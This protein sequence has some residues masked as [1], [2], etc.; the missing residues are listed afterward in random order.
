MRISLIHPVYGH[1]D[2]SENLR[3][4]D[5]EFCK[6]PPIV[7]AY[8]A[9]VLQQAGHTV[10]IIDAHNNKLSDSAILKELEGFAPDLLGVRLETYGFYDTLRLV[11][12][13]KPR[14]ANIKVLCGGINL[15]LYPDES[16]AHGFFDYGLIGDADGRLPEIIDAI[17]KGRDIHLVSGTISYS[18]GEVRITPGQNYPP[19]NYSFDSHPF[20]ARGLLNNGIYYSAISQ[21]RNY[22]IMLASRGCPYKCKFCEI[23]SI[24]YTGRSAQSIIQEIEECY[25]QHG[26]REIDFFDAG[27]FINKKEIGRVFD[28]LTRMKLD[29]EW[30]CRSRVDE[31]DATTLKKARSAGCRQI[32]FGIESCDP[33][34]LFN[35]NKEINGSQVY[36]TLDLCRKT[37][38]R[39]LGFFMIG[40]QGETNE[41]AMRTIK[42]AK[43]LPLDY[44]QFCM[45]IAKPSSGYNRQRILD[46]QRDYW[47]EY[48]R[49]SIPAEP[50][51]RTWTRLTDE[52]VRR[53]T[54]TAYRVF[55]L[56]PAQI[57]RLLGRVRSFKELVRYFRIA[58]RLLVTC[59]SCPG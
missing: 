52:E 21:R 54:K 1:K 41:T 42:Y 7:L 12:Y 57:F 29:L 56:R 50:F 58:A 28:E 47:R 34:I 33:R 9:A 53:L 45:A 59:V 4:I 24:D 5:E 11:K 23:N 3:F 27:F 10:Q 15:S 6:G 22:T 49:G 36:S 13:L 46:T 44:A 31:I 26:V 37:G 55:Y 38:I 35:I 40:N 8:V 2:F 19:K 16:F 20:P 39:A 43:S 48:I 18:G 25:Y 17:G 14:L 30:S 32:Y 51:P